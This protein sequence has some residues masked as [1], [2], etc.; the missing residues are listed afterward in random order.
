MVERRGILISVLDYTRS[1]L[2]TQPAAQIRLQPEERISLHH[3]LIQTAIQLQSETAF[4][5][6]WARCSIKGTHLTAQDYLL[7]F[8]QYIKPVLRNILPLLMQVSVQQ[9]FSTT[10]KP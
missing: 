10:W 9:V 4:L 8:A 5:V 7:L 3:L 1:Q 6:I 2:I